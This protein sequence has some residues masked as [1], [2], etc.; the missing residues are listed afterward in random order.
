MAMPYSDITKVPLFKMQYWLH[1]VKSQHIGTAKAEFYVGSD[2]KDDGQD[3]HLA[4]MEKLEYV[5]TTYLWLC[6]STL[7]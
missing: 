3:P 1:R 5:V 6:T 4:K 7:L 2:V